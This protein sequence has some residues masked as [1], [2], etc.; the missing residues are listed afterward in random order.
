[1]AVAADGD[2]PRAQS[3][4]LG[5]CEVAPIDDDTHAADAVPEIIREEAR[6]VAG[7]LAATGL[8]VSDEQERR[9]A[10]YLNGVREWG[11]RINLVS[12]GDLARLGRRHLL[13]SFN[14]LS[15]PLE[16][17]PRASGRCW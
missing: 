11:R 7:E 6:A 4:L 9:F 13:E 16:A 15:C 10:R 12:T 8:P 2:H 14:I 3:S 17:R 5:R 1:V